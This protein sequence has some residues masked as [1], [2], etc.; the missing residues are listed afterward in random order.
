L[1]TRVAHLP[2]N[3]A[4]E[5]IVGGPQR[6]HEE[7]LADYLVGMVRCDPRRPCGIEH[8]HARCL[9]GSRL[10]IFLQRG[11]FLRARLVVRFAGIRLASLR[12]HAGSILHGG[13]GGAGT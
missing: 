9:L 12:F 1:R 5:I 2:D 13:P 3:A 7:D 6:L 8:L 4:E 10:E 11:Q